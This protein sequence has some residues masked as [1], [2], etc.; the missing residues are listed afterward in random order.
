M[1]EADEVKQLM[2][3]IETTGLAGLRDRAAIAI[4][5][6]TAVRAAGIAKLR[7]GDY[8]GR[9]GHMQLHFREKAGTQ[10]QIEVRSDLEVCL[11][12]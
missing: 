1:I 3:S 12:D 7:P 8:H 11:N 2:A 10:H 5:G 6:Y 4:L 9:P